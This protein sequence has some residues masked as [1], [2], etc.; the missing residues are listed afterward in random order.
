M[1]DFPR[2]EDERK[3]LSAGQGSATTSS[4]HN[5]YSTDVQAFLLI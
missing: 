5:S 1:A 3:A 2:R 4:L